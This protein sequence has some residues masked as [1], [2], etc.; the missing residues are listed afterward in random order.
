MFT[1]RSYVLFALLL[2]ASVFA[3]SAPL[4]TATA[5]TGS[6]TSTIATSSTTPASEVRIVELRGRF[7]PQTK[8]R[9]KNL[10]ENIVHRGQATVDRFAHIST[11][12]ESRI[13][14]IK[15]QGGDA[16][17]AEAALAEADTARTAANNILRTLNDGDVDII[18]DAPVPHDALRLLSTHIANVHANLATTKDALARATHAL[19]SPVPTPV[20]TTT[21]A[22][23]THTKK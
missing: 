18:V 6:S 9:I 4:T 22:S 3:V 14:K 12:I 8:I 17:A 20:A 21:A 10:L 7:A 23:S 1:L 5:D 15:A 19:V 13:Q 2:C 16:S 11:R